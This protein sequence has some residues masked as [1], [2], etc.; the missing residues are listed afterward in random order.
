MFPPVPPEAHHGRHTR[1]RRATS[2]SPQ[3]PREAGRGRL[4]HRWRR[5]GAGCGRDLP[6]PHGQPT[7][8]LG[9]VQLCPSMLS[10]TA[11][12]RRGHAYTQPKACRSN[13]GLNTIC[14]T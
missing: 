13:V 9:P 1:T 4:F 12:P 3:Q 5:R 7:P 14:W 8:P 10:D 6:P 2:C 11:P